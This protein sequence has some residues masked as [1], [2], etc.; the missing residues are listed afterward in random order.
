MKPRTLILVVLIM[1]LLIVAGSCATG[2]KGYVAIE[3]EELFGTWIN[4]DYDDTGK[5]GKI[6]IKP[7][8]TYDE[9]DNSNSDS[10]F[11]KWGY[12]ITDKWTDSDGNT[13]YKF[14]VKDIST[15]D[16]DYKHKYYFLA[17]IDKTGN[18]YEHVFTYFG[19]DFPSEV[20]PNHGH[21]SIFNRQ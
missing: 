20:D 5:N 21:Y 11:L 6:I 14:I 8:G 10:T 13:F 3:D 17:K 9:Y 1:A 12:S 7:E 4:P 19:Q 2:K 16:S 18:V 15:E